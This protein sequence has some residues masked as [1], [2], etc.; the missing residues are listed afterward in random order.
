MILAAGLGLALPDSNVAATPLDARQHVVDLKAFRVIDSE[1][2]PLNYYTSVGDP[3]SHIHAAYPVGAKTTVLGYRIPE[4]KARAV[5]SL[6]WK[7]R[8]VELPAGGN[9]CADGKGD[10][11]ATIYV[12][13]KRGL[14]WYTVKYVWSSVGP[15]GSTCRRKRNLFRA[16]DTVVVESG[17]PLDEWRS[18]T[19]EPDRE[20]RN[21]FE[22]GNPRADVPALIGIGIMSDGDQT[23]S[24]SSADYGEFVLGWK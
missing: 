19:I 7:W 4:S 15:K 13:W 14:R 12:T 3:P 20:F 9:E 22:G 23:R 5:A 1:S 24:R 16:Q 17:P 18:V 2:G 10:S 11:A 21:H 8:A 6:K